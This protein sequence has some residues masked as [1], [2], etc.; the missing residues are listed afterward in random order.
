LECGKGLSGGGDA[1][2]RVKWG[3]PCRTWGWSA[4]AKELLVLFLGTLKI[5]VNA[6]AIPPKPATPRLL[7]AKRPNAHARSQGKQ[8]AHLVRVAADEDVHVH[9]PLHRGRHAGPPL[10]PG[11]VSLN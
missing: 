4:K 3:E 11:G 10:A 5:K 9:L 6:K 8:L 7:E 2:I 1:W